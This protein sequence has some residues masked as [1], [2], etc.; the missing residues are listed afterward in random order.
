MTYAV[1]IL[2]FS[3]ACLACALV[4]EID[5]GDPIDRPLNPKPMHFGATL[6]GACVLVLTVYGFWKLPWY[7][8]LLA[9]LLVLIIAGSVVN[10]AR[11]SFKAPGI[12]IALGGLSTLLTVLFISVTL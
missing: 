1:Y 12:V 3:L 6:G 10:L 8:P 4:L 2:A 9:Y 7:L 5:R 11:R